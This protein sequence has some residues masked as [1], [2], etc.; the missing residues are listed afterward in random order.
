MHQV[1]KATLILLAACLLSFSLSFFLRAEE[2]EI[3]LEIKGETISAR[4][5]GGLLKDII[6]KIK[7][8]KG[9][10]F[11]G[12]ESLFEEKISVEFKDLSIQDGLKRIL[13]KMNYSLMFDQ[14]GKLFGVIL[15]GSSDRDRDGIRGPT[16]FPKSTLPI[17]RPK[18]NEG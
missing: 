3:E 12:G 1:F 8:K 13:S 4:I 14:D 9:I 18:R 10:W 6:E 17:K 7:E 5:K 11:K 15:I 16:V 2:G